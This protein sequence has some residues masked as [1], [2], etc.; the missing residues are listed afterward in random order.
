M[1][2]GSKFQKPINQGGAQFQKTGGPSQLPKVGPQLQKT[3]GPG[4][5]GGGA[6]KFG[7]GPGKVMPYQKANF[8][9][10]KIGNKFAPYTKNQKKY[11]YKGKWETFLPLAA[12][13]AVAIGGGYYYADSYLTWRG[14]I[15]RASPRTA[16]G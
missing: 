7:Q 14:P 2:G 6:F 16:A 5:G 9:A 1:Q 4:P 11:Y 15:A 8:A 13:G 3:G 10:I 12:L